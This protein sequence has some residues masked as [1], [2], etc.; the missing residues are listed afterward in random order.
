[1]CLSHSWTCP[2]S[3]TY[4]HVF[5]FTIWFSPHD[6]SFCRYQV[7]FRRGSPRVRALND[8]GWGI[9]TNWRFSTFKPL[10]LRN[11]AKIR[12]RLLLRKSDTIGTK[13]SDLGWPWNDLNWTAIRTH[14]IAYYTHVFLSQ[15]LLTFVVLGVAFQVIPMK[16]T[17]S[18]TTPVKIKKFGISPHVTKLRHKGASTVTSAMPQRHHPSSNQ[19][20][21]AQKHCHAAQHYIILLSTLTDSYRHLANRFIH[22]TMILL[23]TQYVALG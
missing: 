10:Y 14:P 15:P 13:I 18:A 4:D 7:K 20:N 22:C 8:R 3:P 2:H 12:Q 1:V 21:Q 17:K 23:N 11:G 6:S 19:L 5:F 9:G 16:N